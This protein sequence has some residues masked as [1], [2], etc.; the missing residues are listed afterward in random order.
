MHAIWDTGPFHVGLQNL[1]D[2][3]MWLRLSNIGEIR[4]LDHPIV[5]YRMK[6]NDQQLSG[7]HNDNRMLAEKFWIQAKLPEPRDWSSSTDEHNHLANLVE[8]WDKR[9][10]FYNASQQ[11]F[12]ALDLL[13]Q[14]CFSFDQTVN[15]VLQD[16]SNEIDFAGNENRR[17]AMLRLQHRWP[18]DVNLT[19][20]V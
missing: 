17:N 20:L 12:S 3:E 8:L 6:S 19:D 13:K 14:I 9:G 15:S 10:T 16:M 7:S 5:R 18:W 2:Y 4:I 11:F 1:Q